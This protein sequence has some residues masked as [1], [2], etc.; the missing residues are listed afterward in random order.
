MPQ[1]GSTTTQNRKCQRGMVDRQPFCALYGKIFL[2][3]NYF[4]GVLWLKLCI[5]LAIYSVVL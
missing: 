1:L 3:M 4:S 5:L 2:K